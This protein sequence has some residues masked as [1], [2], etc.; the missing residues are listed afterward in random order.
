MILKLAVPMYL[1]S[2]LSILQETINLAFIGSLKDEKLYSGVGAGNMLVN[3]LGFSVLFG[4][5]SGLD[6]YVSKYVG[7]KQ[8]KDCALSL[9]RGRVMICGLL[10]FILPIQCFAGQILKATG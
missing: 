6:V 3:L 8:Y 9:Y 2:V 1:A 4:F 7:A 5:N 10:V